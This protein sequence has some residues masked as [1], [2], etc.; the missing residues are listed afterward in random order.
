MR[1]RRTSLIA[2]AV[3]MTTTSLCASGA[4]AAAAPPRTTI[5][6]MTHDSFAVSKK[7]L[8]GFEH[9][10]GITVKILQSGD[11]GAALNQ[12][13]LTKDHPLG[14]VFFGVDNTLLSR[15]LQEGVFEPYSPPGLAGVPAEFQLDPSH[16]L[17]PV[18]TGD[19]C[20][21]YD[22]SY[23]ADHH[24]AV[25]Q[26]LADLARPQYKGLLTVEN[27]AT[28]SPGLAFLIASV[29]EFGNDGWQDYWKKL[30]DNDVHVVDGWEQAYN[31]DF[32]GSA[33]HGDS[34]L[35]VSY[36]SSPPA[37]VIYADPRPDHAPTAALLKTCFR[38]T[39]FV[40]V[41]R[42]TEHARAARKLVDFMLSP[43]F[44]RDMPL[45]MFVYPVVPG[46]ALP[47]SFVKYAKVAPHPFSLSP[48]Q[49][50]EHR[51]QW[52]DQWT[53]TVLR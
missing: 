47:P 22:K 4:A 44:Q 15:A 52:I 30:R 12:A 20:V 23:F 36:A 24:L 48:K 14:D 10:T 16:R 9:R 7:V 8:A 45:Q 41:L 38:Q 18:D 35:V 28:S 25:P 31:E 50:T 33:G 1:M 3:A 17:T 2:V 42:G 34:P 37:E 27:P 32:S 51:D 46:V 21:N 11:A 26:T 39:E 5:T 19:V 49:I 53:D 13:I 6:L 40:G 43:R 29:A